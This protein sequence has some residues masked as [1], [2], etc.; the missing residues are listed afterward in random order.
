M[1]I[2]LSIVTVSYNVSGLLAECLRAVYESL[3]D[4]ALRFEVWVI[5]NASKDDSVARVRHEFPQVQLVANEQNRGF[6]AANNQGIQLAQGRFILLL[7][8]DTRVL[9]HAIEKLIAFMEATPKAGMVGARLL[10]SDGSFQ[11]SAFGFPTLAQILFDFFPLHHRLLNSRLNGRYP[12]R[13]YESGKPFPI[14]HP[15]GASML[16]RRP[17]IEQVGALDERFFMY[18]EEVEWAMRIR[19]AGWEIYCV[20]QA[21]IIHHVGQSTNQFRDR[22]FI[23]LWRS[24]FLLFDKAYSPA[25]RLAARQL[26]RLGVRWEMRKLARRPLSE[27]TEKRRAAYETALQM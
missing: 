21:E 16:V 15:L 14:D 4:S 23:A 2:D 20:P 12:R 27:E 6:A 5:D 8:P 7:N 26:V 1:S 19:R 17:V 11:H 10:H 25:F 13:L 22:M 24:R 9:G 18:C 3:A